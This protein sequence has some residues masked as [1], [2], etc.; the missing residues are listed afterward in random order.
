M[1]GAPTPP[2]FACQ[3]RVA[4]VSPRVIDSLVGEDSTGARYLNRV[5]EKNLPIRPSPRKH[6]R[7]ESLKEA[8]IRGGFF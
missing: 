7:H 4:G 2:S 3:G 5:D 8:S 6:G 1:G